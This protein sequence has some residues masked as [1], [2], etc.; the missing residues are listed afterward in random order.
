[1]PFD[2]LDDQI[3]KLESQKDKVRRTFPK[4]KRKGE[5]DEGALNQAADQTPSKSPIAK[6]TRRFLSGR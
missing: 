6:M 3:K 5:S 4:A 1:M 2:K